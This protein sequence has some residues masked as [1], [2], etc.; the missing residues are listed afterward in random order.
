MLTLLASQTQ[1]V[2]DRQTAKL[3]IN[4]AKV[5]PVARSLAPCICGSS[6]WSF[7]CVF[8]IAPAFL[9]WLL[10]FWEI[11]APMLTDNRKSKDLRLQPRLEWILPSSGLLR[12]VSWLKTDVSGPHISPLFKGQASWTAWPLKMGPSGGSETSTLN[13]LTLCNGPEDGRIQKA[14]VGRICCAKCVF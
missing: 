14:N 4:K 3:F 7:L 1:T 13:H 2:T 11:C 6:V 12:G 10:D 9:R 5:I 8:R